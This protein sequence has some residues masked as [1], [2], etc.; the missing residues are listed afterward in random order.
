MK[1]KNPWTWPLQPL[2]GHTKQQTMA[3]I[4]LILFLTFAYCINFCILCRKNFLFFFF[5]ARKLRLCELVGAPPCISANIFSFWG[6]LCSRTAKI[7]PPPP[8]LLNWVMWRIIHPHGWL[9]VNHVQA[10][11]ALSEITVSKKKK[12]NEIIIFCQ[13]SKT[14]SQLPTNINIIPSSNRPLAQKWMCP[15]HD[16]C[17]VSAS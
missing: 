14:Q 10:Q 15:S 2:Q 13:E 3:F 12:K 9:R 4:Q 17:L 16:Y 1:K 6:S 7:P 5:K 11:R 8:P